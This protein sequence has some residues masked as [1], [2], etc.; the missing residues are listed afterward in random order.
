M[1][2]SSLNMRMH[3]WSLRAWTW[4]IHET[5]KLE[6]EKLSM[7]HSS[8]NLLA[9]EIQSLRTWIW[10]SI[11]EAFELHFEAP[12]FAVNLYIILHKVVYIFNLLHHLITRDEHLEFMDFFPICCDSLVEMNILR[13]GKSLF[14]G[15]EISIF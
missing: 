1:K 10:E 11:D 12:F 7:K 15:C 9:W 6:Y 2:L 4:S 5:F 13:F 8:F 3:R 14:N